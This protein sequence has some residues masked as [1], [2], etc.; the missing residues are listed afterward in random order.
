[1]QP[2]FDDVYA[3]R[4]WSN[5]GDG[6]G[7]GSTVEFTRAL[8]ATLTQH[9][10]ELGAGLDRPVTFVDAP[11]GA[12]VWTEAWL[13]E[14]RQAELPLRYFGYDVASEPVR[15]A[16]ARL[17]RFA[18]FHHISVVPC[19]LSELSA[20]APPGPVDIVLCRDLLQHLCYRSAASVLRGLSS[21]AARSFLITTYDGPN[22]AIRDGDYYAV[23][24]SAAPFHLRPSRCTPEDPENDRNDKRISWF[25]EGGELLRGANATT[26][27]PRIVH[28]VWLAPPGGNAKPPKQYGPFRQSFV[29]HN[30]DFEVRLWGDDDVEALWRQEPFLAYRALRDKALHIERCDLARYAIL[31][32][33]GGVYVDLN[34]ECLQPLRDVLAGRELALVEEP[35]QHSAIM[36]TAD[37]MLSNSFLASC[38]GHPFWL[39]LMDGIAANYFDA[40]PRARKRD[41]CASQHRPHQLLETRSRAAR[42]RIARRFARVDLRAS[43]AGVRQEAK[44]R[45]LKRRNS[46]SHLRQAL[47]VHHSLGRQSRGAGRA[48]GSVAPLFCDAEAE[49]RPL[50][51]CRLLRVLRRVLRACAGRLKMRRGGVAYYVGTPAASGRLRLVDI[52]RPTI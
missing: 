4:K 39:Q 45:L 13:E 18:G 40:T 37:R 42:A 24:L 14:L 9:V 20:A 6:S 49:D 43:A 11:C 36:G 46:T 25:S 23:D 8:R 34:T 15:K 29:D 7:P 47:V 17:Q 50:R 12:C 32:A 27:I 33:H 1:M 30:P 19:E 21:V 16:H 48:A 5:E 10:R 35:R 41:F 26:T 51:L 38:A 2:V 31:F 52:L 3:K 44:Q 28:H 22:K